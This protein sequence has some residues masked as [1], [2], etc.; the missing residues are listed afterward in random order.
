MMGSGG[1][2][3][4]SKMLTTTQPA[5]DTGGAQVSQGAQ[6]GVSLASVLQQAISMA[7]SAQSAQSAQQGQSRLQV[8]SELLMTLAEYKVCFNLF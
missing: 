5:G 6:G 1:I 4:G 7:Q 3:T 2:L 8:L